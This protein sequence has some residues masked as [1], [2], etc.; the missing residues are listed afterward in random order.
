MGLQTAKKVPECSI[1][2]SAS[3]EGKVH[4]RWLTTS[5]YGMTWFNIRV[6]FSSMYLLFLWQILNTFCVFLIQS[7]F[8]MVWSQ[9]WCLSWEEKTVCCC[10]ACL[11]STVLYTRSLDM[12]MWFWNSAGGRRNKVIVSIFKLYLM[13]KTQFS[14][15]WLPLYGR[16]CPTIGLNIFSLWCVVHFK[17]DCLLLL[18]YFFLY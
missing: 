9:W 5:L 15:F 13:G 11:T 10:G 17:L 14:F 4:G 7:H 8:L 1:L 18:I 12:M 16:Q 2:S 6:W 3:L